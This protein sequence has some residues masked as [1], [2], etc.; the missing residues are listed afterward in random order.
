MKT[1]S[2]D[3]IKQARKD[4]WLT[5][6]QAAALIHKGLRTWQGW[7]TDEA[8]PGHRKMDP[9]FWEL[10]LIK[11]RAF[12]KTKPPI[13]L[14]ETTLGTVVASSPICKIITLNNEAIAN[15]NPTSKLDY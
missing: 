5:Q 7:E 13:K 2:P 4:A 15:V 9:A 8:L 14:I 12:N 3:Q 11:I 10:F 6:S 1:P